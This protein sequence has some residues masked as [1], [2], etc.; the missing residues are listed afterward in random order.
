MTFKNLQLGSCEIGRTQTT[1]SHVSCTK[2]TAPLKQPYCSM[3]SKKL[4][5]GK[6]GFLWEGKE[7]LIK[8]VTYPIYA[9]IHSPWEKNNREATWLETRRAEN[10]AVTAER[11]CHFLTT[12]TDACSRLKH[13]TNSCVWG[14]WREAQWRMKTEREGWLWPAACTRCN[15]DK[16]VMWLEIGTAILSLHCVFSS[17]P[18]GISPSEKIETSPHIRLKEDAL[19]GLC[20]MDYNGIM[21]QS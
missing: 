8:Q 1:L 14:S 12:K 3:R 21:P 19:R 18:S 11:S 13:A 9:W 15:R 17:L 6:R 7:N 10:S 16:L 2:K 4:R 5:E 20:L